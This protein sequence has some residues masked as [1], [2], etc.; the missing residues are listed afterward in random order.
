M[1]LYENAVRGMPLRAEWLFGDSSSMTQN[2]VTIC[3][4]VLGDILI[5]PDCADNYKG[6]PIVMGDFIQIIA[7]GKNSMSPLIDILVQ[8]FIEVASKE[9]P[10]STSKNS[11]PSKPTTP[12]LQTPILRNTPK[13]T[14]QSTTKAMWCHKHPTAVMV[15]TVIIGVIISIMGTTFYME[16]SSDSSS[17]LLL[18]AV[19]CL[20]MIIICCSVFR[21]LFERPIL[22]AILICLPCLFG[23]I[24][25]FLADE[26]VDLAVWYTGFGIIAS[27]LIFECYWLGNPFKIQHFSWVIIGS[28][29]LIL[30]GNVFGIT[31]SGKLLYNYNY[32]SESSIN[33]QHQDTE[34]SQINTR[35][36]L[37]INTKIIHKKIAHMLDAYPTQTKATSPTNSPSQM[38]STT[39]TPTAATVS[40]N[41]SPTILPTPA[42]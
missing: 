35:Y 32:S 4:T 24:L 21:R 38:R 10:R 13:C 29:F 1:D 36:V 30:V 25:Y 39:A 3:A 41:P 9:K 18:P 20:V 31:Y 19:Y 16:D 34:N 33:S 11:E 2:A 22:S 5:N 23:F 40:T 27:L 8:F 28:I 37:N 17:I 7:F 14:V 6:A 26:T 12:P 42:K 15:L